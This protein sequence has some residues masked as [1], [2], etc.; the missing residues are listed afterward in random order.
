MHQ[1]IEKLYTLIQDLKTKQEFEK[2]INE[3]YQHYNHL[4]EKN[5]IATLI[6]DELGRNTQNITPI[7]DIQTNSEHTVIATITHIS[8]TKTFKRKN[9]TKGKIQ[10]I[11][12]TDNTATCQLILWNDDINLLTTKNIQPGTTIKIINAYTKEGYNGKE[13]HVGRWGT[14]EPTTPQNHQNQSNTTIVQQETIIEGKLI[15]KEPTKAFFKDNGDFG[16]VTTITIQSKNTENKLTI[17]DTKV[18]EIQ[19]L[20]IGDKIKITNIMTKHNNGTKELHVN[21]KSHI[22]KY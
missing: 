19:N 5:I 4:F 16:F 14:V 20:K 22:Q 10:K 21:G 8:E 7:K 17:W 15:T 18:K 9:G 6:V 13:L 12:I 2:E 3:H 1:T 11:Q